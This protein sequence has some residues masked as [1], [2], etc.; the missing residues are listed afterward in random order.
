MG[1]KK[2]IS[3]ILFCFSAMLASNANAQNYIHDIEK[4]REGLKN[5]CRTFD[6]KYIYYPYDSVNKATDSMHG[7]CTV[8]GN[9]YYYKI[10][11]GNNTYEYIKN[12]KYCIVIDN[13]NKAIAVKS[14]SSVRQDLWS[15]DGIDS[16]LKKPGVKLTYKSLNKREGQYVVSYANAT[17]WN[18]IRIV[19]DKETYSLSKIWL[20][21][22][23]KG[24]LL[25]EPYNR[26]KL[27]IYYAQRKGYIPDESVF[28]EKRCIENNGNEIELTEKYK[29]YRLLNYL[30]QSKKS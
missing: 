28:S 21:S 9:S 23:A 25:G 24:K 16:L 13:P 6:M 26:P 12:E 20:S 2:K 4:I 8:S 5:S 3:C 17:P 11:S 15:V 30:N 14:S 27:G 1:N 29:K 7:I 10:S 18:K 19:F 22:D